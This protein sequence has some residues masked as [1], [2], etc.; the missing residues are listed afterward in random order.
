MQIENGII[1]QQRYQIINKIASGG[2]ADVYRA[3]DSFLNRIVAIKILNQQAANNSQVL[4]KFYKE[5]EATT[6]I[7]H[8]NVVEVYDVFEQDNR[9]CIVLELVEGY[10]LKDR[11]LRTGPLS[12]KECLQIFQSILDGVAVAHQGNI[13]HR[14][15][16]PENILI[17]FDGKIKVSDFG[18]AII[19]DYDKTT[20]TK[21]VG[22]AK[23][24][25]PETVQSLQ[26]DH[27]S[28]I[29]SLGIVLFELL[30]GSCPF[31]GQ[32]PTLVAV[33]QVREPLPSAR[34]INPNI[35]QALENIIIKSTA[36]NCE[37]RYQS[38]KALSQDIKALQDISNAKIKPLK[39]KNCIVLTRD[40]RKQKIFIKNREQLMSYFLTPKFL[41]MIAIITSFIF[42]VFLLLVFYSIWL[43]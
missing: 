9:W 16:K 10:T 12:I 18:I 3:N 15:L 28:D 32:N 40:N 6:R 30:T 31:N 23:Y 19:T 2:M 11:L 4:K 41:M 29:Y 8:D 33:K 42:L 25:S 36:K 17:S 5:V 35:S 14:D 34:G 13:V 27:R 26:I 22:T 38:I 7:R 1:L 43:V 20:T 37:E 39:L 24:I 21:I